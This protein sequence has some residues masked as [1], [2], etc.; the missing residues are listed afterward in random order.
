MMLGVFA[1]FCKSQTL[2]PYSLLKNVKGQTQF[3]VFFKKENNDTQFL[4]ENDVRQVLK[5]T[6]SICTHVLVKQVSICTSYEEKKG[7]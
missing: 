5:V 2:E 3:L 1:V 4:R 7:K 6:A